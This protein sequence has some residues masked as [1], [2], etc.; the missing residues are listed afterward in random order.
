MFNGFR[1]Y[2]WVIGYFT[3]G[4]WILWKMHKNG[5]PIFKVIGGFIV[6]IGLLFGALAIYAQTDSGM[7]HDLQAAYLKDN[8][9]SAEKI[10]K[11]NPNVTTKEGLTASEVVEKIKSDLKAEADKKAEAERIAKE[12]AEA[13]RIANIEPFEINHDFIGITSQPDNKYISNY[14]Y[15][16]RVKQKI[17][18][19]NGLLTIIDYEKDY[20]NIYKIKVTD[21]ES[22]LILKF[23]KGSVDNSTGVTWKYHTASYDISVIGLQS[24]ETVRQG[25]SS[26]KRTGDMASSVSFQKLDNFL[27]FK[28]KLISLN[29]SVKIE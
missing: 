22:L 14:K 20:E 2:D 27:W 24:M 12:K 26:G 29:P 23:P 10:L 8:L 11:E 15:K 16:H 4:L 28:K 17:L 7:A 6:V 25:I 18:Y 13:E 19:S 21:L 1:W 3:F 9:S 5:V